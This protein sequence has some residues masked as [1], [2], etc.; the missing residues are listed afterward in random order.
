MDFNWILIVWSMSASA[1]LTLAVMH[2]I[3]WLKDTSARAHLLFLLAA[4]AAVAMA[5]CE[6]RMM[7]AQ[8]PQ[9]YSDAVRWA[10]VPI[11]VLI[12]SLTGF[13]MVHLRA[14]RRWLA[15]TV[16]VVRTFALLLN[17]LADQNLNFREVTGLHG[18]LFLGELVAVPDAAASAWTL[19]G[20][21]G[22][23][24]F[25]AFVVDASITVWRRGE[26]HLALVTGGSIVLCASAGTVQIT[27]IVLQL[28]DW[29]YMGSLFYMA[30]V[31]AAS[32]EMGNSLVA[33][34]QTTSRLQASEARLLE[35]EQRLDDAAGAAELGSWEWNVHREEIWATDRCRA[36]FGI[37]RN[38]RL[39]F[40]GVLDIVH[41]EDRDTLLKALQTSLENRAALE[42]EYRVLLPDGSMRWIFTRGRVTSA[43]GSSESIL[44]G[45][46]IDI[47][48]RKQLEERFRRVVDVAPVGL[49]I[50]G[51]AGTI[52]LVNPWIES[53][54]GYG[55]G[56][57]I[58]QH[59]HA[60]F[61]RSA[62]H[63]LDGEGSFCVADSITAGRMAG[64]K[65]TGRRADG[66]ELELEIRADSVPAMNGSGA[67]ILVTM[68]DITER[69]RSQRALA[70]ERAFLRQVID[71]DPNLIF[72]KDR[73]GRFT[74]ANQ[75]VA[76]I[77]GTTV[78][79]LIGKTDAD[80]NSKPEEVAH[81]RQVDTEVMD[82]LDERR[83]AEEEI[84]DVHGRVHFLQTVKRPI[85][86]PDDVAHQLVGTA[87]DITARKRAEESIRN[88]EE[89]N[90]SIL[91]S[92]QDHVVILDRDGVV[93]AVND[94]WSEFRLPPGTPKPL[95][96]WSV[97][98]NYLDVCTYSPSDRDAT[99]E[100]AREGIR[101]VLSG[102]S[103]LFSMEYSPSWPSASG[104]ILMR[105]L[106][107]KRGSGGVVISHR[108]ITDRKEAELEF[109]QQRN[110][111]AHFSRVTMLGQLSGS[112]AHELNQ[113]LAAILS[114]AQA[115]LRFLAHDNYDREEVRE[116]LCDIVSDDKRAGDVIQGLRMLL[117]K[118]ETRHELV[119]L[120][121]MVRDVAK[122][123]R[124]E[125]VNAR[126]TLTMDLAEDLPWVPGDRVQ[127]EQV[128]L[129]LVVNGSDAM[130]NSPVH[131]RQLLVG[132]GRRGSDELEVFV[133]DHGPGLQ[134]EE[135]EKVFEPFYTTKV[136]GLGLG[137]V[138]SRKI[139]NAHGGRL[140]AASNSHG[141]ATFSFSL[142]IS[143][144]A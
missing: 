79:D 19:V 133:V 62:R 104:W 5:F 32:Y 90:R 64:L 128:L 28:L 65:S 68:I 99:G 134:P 49:M 31:G 15:W 112:L 21:L 12:L 4:V 82:S 120:N 105:V 7:W 69:E 30:I 137:L 109:V 45:V 52:E 70:Q 80:F 59:I 117:K 55:N 6:L 43:A 38:E 91:S 14:G 123:V 48:A 11:W 130:A 36:L 35:T 102:K 2:L 135:I 66:S 40:R 114:N 20:T 73:Q 86:G 58:G 127:I 124:S 50:L 25:I 144:G 96:E 47:S 63:R 89:F 126:V 67:Q 125:M 101:S 76:D 37:A 138:V 116:I 57:L 27:L 87:T 122:L 81:F 34:A 8:T 119:D 131:E 53:T 1:S 113:P 29:P 118:G 61:P 10:H 98:C 140:Q 56:K 22:M 110:E 94:A 84:T 78:Q 115:A 71:I 92:L 93:L 121:E 42:A 129:N 111:L 103:A 77:Y 39:E 139:V 33:A 26:R 13:V 9:E 107:L 141:G 74:L 17:F 3:V 23:L 44:H 106:P 97:G 108:D 95:G 142:P 16:V 51:Q 88:S 83:V 54:F 72:A 60:L 132:T 24:L 18:T 136:G 143:P 85:V 41:P 75:A 46:S 100:R